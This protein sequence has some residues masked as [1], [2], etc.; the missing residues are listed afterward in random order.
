MKKLSKVTLVASVVLATL[1]LSACGG[2]EKTSSASG[3]KSED[4][5]VLTV[6]IDG[7]WYEKFVNE[8][9]GDFEKENNVEVKVENKPMTDQL[10]ALPLDGPAGLAADV[11]MAPFDRVG[12]LAQQ[13]HLMEVETP[14]D[15]RFDE[16]TL[17]M[18]K[19]NGKEYAYPFVVE[20]L[21]M[22]YNKDLISEAPTSF[23]DLEELSK[24]KRFDFKGEEGKNIGFLANW[25]D[26]NQAYGLIAGYGGYVFGDEGTNV[27][28][29]GINN[30]G[31]IEGIEYISQWYKNTWPQGMKDVKGAGDFKNQSFIK[32]ENAANIAGTWMIGDFK[33]SGINLGTAAIP[34]LPN[35]EKYQPFAGGKGWIASEYSKEPELAQKWLD[36][37]TND[38]SAKIFYETT[39]ELPINKQ[40]RED[41]IKE[42]KDELAVAVYNQ[43]EDLTPMPIVPEMAEVWTGAQ[44]MLFDAVSGN[45][46]AKESADDAVKVIESTI[47]EKY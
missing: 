1:A 35:G 27:K 10:E 14:S 34:T 7:P 4:K 20:T 33:D 2:K 43:F 29:I 16:Q 41:I 9:K 18:A 32:G 45:K 15:D 44:T 11:M 21:V 36:Y 12:N 46:T 37:V 24:D 25:I 23:S 13:G 26:F 30:E 3:E 38:K 28:D 8:V 22:Y 5:K 6:S 47:K 19:I 31:A 17:S 42:N 39:S 40:V